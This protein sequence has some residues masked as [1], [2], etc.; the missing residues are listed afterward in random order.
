MKHEFADHLCGALALG[1][2]FTVSFA[3]ML[4]ERGDISP[5]QPVLTEVAS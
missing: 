2:A 3:A 5:A 1:C 4:D